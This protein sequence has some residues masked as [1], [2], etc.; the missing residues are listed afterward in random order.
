VKGETRAMAK[1]GKSIVVALVLS[2]LAAAGAQPASPGR[3]SDAQKHAVDP[4]VVVKPPPAGT[5][6]IRKPPA[7]VDR[8]IVET[9]PTK[10]EAANSNTGPQKKP[11]DPGC[12]GSSA[13][14]NHTLPR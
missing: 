2:W 14:C 6:T 10:E 3:N 12:A 7:D 4:G 8:G 11:R 9:P 5:T 1:P 13:S